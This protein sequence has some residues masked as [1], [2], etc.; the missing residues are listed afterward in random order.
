[1]KKILLCTLICTAVAAQAETVFRRDNGSEPKSIDPQLASEDA[2]ANVLYDTFEGL[3]KQTIAGNIVPGMAESWE[4]SPDGKT[5]TFHLRDALW[6]DGT[7]VSAED[8]VYA[9]Q[10]AV[11]P[12]TGSEYAF[13]LYPVKNAEAIATGEEKNPATLGVKA[14]DARTLIVTLNHPTP[15]FLELLSHYTT[16]PVPQKVVEAYGNQW[17]KP[18]H[19]VS[20]GAY[21][22]SE[23]KPQA[24]ISAVKSDTYWNKNQVSIDKVIYYPIEDRNAAFSRYRAGELDYVSSLAAEQLDWS[25]KEIPGQLHINPYLATYY[26]GFNLT[27]APF[28]DNLKLRK[29]LTIAIDRQIIVD[30]VTKAGQIPA[31]SIVP[32]STNNAKPYEPDYAKLSRS[33]QIE[34]ARKLYQ[35]AGYSNDKPL[36]VNLV[37]NTNETHKKIAVAVAAMW[38]QILGVQTSLENKEWK[39][40]LSDMAQKKANL[41]RYSWIGDYNDPYTFLE[42]FQANSGLN[43]PGY[44][45]SAYDAKLEQA[46]GTQDLQKRADILYE[47][48]KIFT[49]DYAIA[50]LYHYVSVILLK[51]N[52]KGYEPNIMKN[53]PSQYLRIEN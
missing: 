42:L 5:Y 14:A 9:W 21:H 30:R 18:A 35:E 23:W 48:E 46:A 6:S 8:F 37:Y 3:T 53:M 1:M 47:A 32:P 11:N 29:A 20:N 28:K 15:Y 33:N 44:M 4:V 41:F 19:F 24:Q 51:P 13:I 34:L 49:D 7:P 52:I 45:N 16:F 2:G 39:V 27:K 17:T 38:K 36:K 50:P 12:S 26:F 22:L 43:H 10:R 25:R 40:L 31:Y